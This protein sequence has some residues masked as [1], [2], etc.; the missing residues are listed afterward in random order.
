MNVRHYAFHGVG[1]TISSEDPRLVEAI[2]GRLRHFRR[3]VGDPGSLEFRFRFVGG[4][5]EHAVQR[6]GGRGRPVYE[7]PEGEVTYFEAEDVLYI[8]YVDRVR[9]LCA[10]GGASVATSALA[11]ER[12]SLWL[13]SRPLFTL[14]LVELLKRR[15]LYSV[16]AAGLAADGQA[17]LVAGGSGS[18]KSTL[19][20]ALLRAGFEFLGD[21]ML[22]LARDADGIRVCSFPDEIDVADET[23]SWF[24]ELVPLA[25]AG[26]RSGDWPKHRVRA[27]EAYAA[28]FVAACPPGIVV[29]PVISHAEESV[30]E[31][32]SR[33]EALRDLAPNV[34]LTAPEPAQAHLDALGDLVRDS[35]CYRLV[36]ARDFERVAELVRALTRP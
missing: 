32:L 4:P 33:D 12:D 1:I 31:P 6:P 22:F 15:G 8:D 17:I 2:D 21:D 23:L 7:P 18:G 5:E 10:A 19:A 28:G 34:L 11:S 3:H 24:P 26:G 20:L 16:H 9:V 14:P 27:E 35:E 36:A 25:A 30:L 29:F 13:L